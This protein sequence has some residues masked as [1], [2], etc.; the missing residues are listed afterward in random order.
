M[1]RIEYVGIVLM[2]VFFYNL[3]IETNNIVFSLMFLLY[4]ICYTAYAM[5]VSN[6]KIAIN[7][8]SNIIIVG[9]YYVLVVKGISV[10]VFAF[11]I[12]TIIM[13]CKNLVETLSK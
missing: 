10:E 12:C 3:Y 6:K 2:S 1:K 11:L 7:I 4:A 13:I 9:L 5:H 8:L